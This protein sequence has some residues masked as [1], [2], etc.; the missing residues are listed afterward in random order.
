ML[1]AD[2]AYVLGELSNQLAVFTL[3]DPGRPAVVVPAYGAPLPDGNLAATLL[4]TEPR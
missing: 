3:A 1:E 4:R 2:H